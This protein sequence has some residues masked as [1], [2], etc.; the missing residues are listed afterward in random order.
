MN[1]HIDHPDVLIG[2]GVMSANL[3]KA[4]MATNN[5]NNAK[6]VRS[7]I[8]PFATSVPF[9]ANPVRPFCVSRVFRG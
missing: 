3:G 4:F 9:V 7:E 6:K 5:T 8:Y 2:S 1:T